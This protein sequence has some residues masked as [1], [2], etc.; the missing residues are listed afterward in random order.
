MRA[1]DACLRFIAA[2]EG[3]VGHAYKPVPAER[4]WTIGYGHYGPDVHPGMTMSR[5]QALVVLRR[6]VGWAEAAVNG[7]IA[8]GARFDQGQFDAL[9]DL[10]FNC[11]P[12]CLQGS[13]GVLAR[14]RENAEIPRYILMYVHGAGGVVLQGLVNRRRL[15]VA[16]FNSHPPRPVSNLSFMTPTER[17]WCHDWDAG[18]RSAELRS[19]MVAR[20]KLIY[21]L[22]KHGA[23]GWDVANRR[24]RYHALLSRT[25]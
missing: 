5:D 15:D 17:A 13:I 10:T 22:A 7:L 12:G 6:D 3:F 20:R 25:T 21:H 2:Q 14:R 19:V 11:G 24:R 8:Q 1:S 4:Y 18:H 16:M 9:V 23:K